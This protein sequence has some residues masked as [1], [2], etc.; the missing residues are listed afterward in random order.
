VNSDFSPPLFFP[1]FPF[2]I[3]LNAPVTVHY[4]NVENS[5]VQNQ[6]AY[7]TSNLELW[8]LNFNLFDMLPVPLCDETL[9]ASDN[10]GNACPGTGSYD[11]S[12]SYTLPNAGNPKT[13]WFATGWSGEGVIQ[14]FA[15]VDETMKIGECILDLQTFVTRQ[16]GSSSLL[17]FP[18][19]A[20]ASGIFLALFLLFIL[21]SMYCMLCRRARPI[22][23][24][25]PT[26][27]NDDDTYFTKMED[28]KSYKS[29]KSKKSQ[30]SLTSGSAS[31]KT[32][33]I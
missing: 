5:G 17:V 15:Q 22:G 21:V 1:F 27:S 2:F 25:K 20:V 12:V 6:L 8:T 9:V 14:M 29:S 26:T 23:V 10:N 32:E 30:K 31:V 19:A 24:K 3:F 4:N 28:T 11:F 13:S 7:M 33:L 18:S 16:D